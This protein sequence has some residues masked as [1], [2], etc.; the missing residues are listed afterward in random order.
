[1]LGL[2]SIIIYDYNLLSVS[3]FIILSSALASFLIEVLN[4]LRKNHGGNVSYGVSFVFSRK[5]FFVDIIIFTSIIVFLA[6]NKAASSLSEDNY[7]LLLFGLYVNWFLSSLFGHRF[8]PK[9]RIKNYWN[10]IWLYLKA[11]IILFALNFFLI[12]IL[13]LNKL[14]SSN[15]ILLTETYSFISFVFVT[16]FFLLRKPLQHSDYKYKYLKANLLTDVAERNLD[17]K[18]QLPYKPSDSSYNSLTLRE[19]LKNVY[20][21][22]FPGLYDF[23]EESVD[24]NSFDISYS[25]TIRSR[26]IYNIE[27]L[28]ESYLKFFLNLHQINDIRRI[29][30]YFIEVNKRLV[31]EGIFIGRFETIS[32][33]HKRFLQKFPFYLAQSFYFLDF[34][35]RRVFPKI[36]ILQKIYFSLTKGYNRAISFAEGLGRLYYCGFE[37]INLMEVDN[38]ICFTAKKV[39]EP[40]ED[41]AP[42]YGP[43]FKMK[44]SGVNGDPI[45]VY[46]LRTMHPYSEYLQKFVFEKFSLKNGGKFNNDFRITYWGKIFRKLWLDELPMLINFVRGDLKL[47][48]VR[49]LSEHYLNLYRDCLKEKRKNH[50]PGLIPPFYVDMPNT[51]DE[52]MDSEERYL[53]SYEKHPFVTDFKYFFRAGYNIVL[54]RARSA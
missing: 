3:R 44:R 5:A 40:V 16:V 35:W 39:K 6:F 38:F 32:L 10:F 17:F 30:N 34:I 11:Y 25:V 36:P 15:V 42:S 51:L 52:I 37:I 2:L 48:G 29:N 50:K 9:F 7:V 21:K 31:N 12:F 4:I 14:D 28:P 27:I 23:I 45:Y 13:R 18:D 54:K 53:D 41:T 26:D 1:M 19:K 46:K 43:L 49:P 24:L 33:R 20:L 8:H 47:V 22:K